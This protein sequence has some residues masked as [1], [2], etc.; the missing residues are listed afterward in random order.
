MGRAI[1]QFRTDAIQIKLSAA[2]LGFVLRNVHATTGRKS[3]RFDTGGIY[4]KLSAASLGFVLR[5]A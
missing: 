5:N 2:S 3:G 1:G 4:R